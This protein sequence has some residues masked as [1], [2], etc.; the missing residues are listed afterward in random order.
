MNTKIKGAAPKLNFF[1]ILIIGLVAIVLVFGA[2]LLFVRAGQTTEPVT[3]RYT[4]LVK[5]LVT[6]IKI[7]L[8][9]GQEVTDT[10]RLNSLGKVISYNIVPTTYNGFDEETKTSF[11]GTYDDLNSVEIVI[12]ATCVMGEMAY[13]VNG[14]PVSVGSPIYFRTP[15]FTSKGY[16]TALAI[17]GA[18]LVETET[19]E[20]TTEPE[21]TG[22]ETTNPPVTDEQQTSAVNA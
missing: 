21:T 22:T 8:E 3:V 5:D 15:T 9:E 1:D 10:V 2:V 20:A 6:D 14:V 18:P 17:N 11:I 4:V 13:E 7:N 12:E 19:A 16:V